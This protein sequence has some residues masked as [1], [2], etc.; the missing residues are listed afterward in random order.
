MTTS[1]P[2]TYFKSDGPCCVDPTDQEVASTISY[3]DSGNTWI[4]QGDLEP[5]LAW[6][7]ANSSSG[8]T[9]NYETCADASNLTNC[10]PHH[11]FWGDKEAYD[12]SSIY[13]DLE[14]IPANASVFSIDVYLPYLNYA[15]CQNDTGHG[16]LGC[17]YELFPYNSATLGYSVGGNMDVISVAEVCNYPCTTGGLLMSAYTSQ[18]GASVISNLNSITNTTFTPFHRLTI[19][20]NRKNFIG[21]YV[22]NTLVYSNNTMPIE[23]N[24][25]YGSPYV[26]FSLRTSINN[27]TLSVTYSNFTA[28][29]SSSVFVT[30][31]SSGMTAIVNGTDGF[32][33]TASAN[34]SGVATL[35]VVTEPTNLTVSVELDGKLIAT[36]NQQIEIGAILDLETSNSGNIT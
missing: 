34:S 16:S 27:Q 14:N 7:S 23:Q 30:G 8:L 22:D 32:N 19:A 11:E 20:T 9:I 33:A 2:T 21:F 4:L 6:A 10:G 25:E 15:N 13:G 26:E 17:T 3:N 36:Y 28:Y 5:G 12:D 24:T 35:N 18:G 31:L 29:T 1:L